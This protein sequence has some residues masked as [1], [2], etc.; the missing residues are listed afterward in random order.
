MSLL[1][2]YDPTPGAVLNPT[3]Y[4][5]PIP[6]FPETV[7]LTFQPAL[8]AHAGSMEGARV[9]DTSHVF[10]ELPVYAVP[11]KGRELAVCQ[12]LLGAAGSAAV[13]EETIARG[14][15]KFLLFGSCGGLDRSIPPGHVL[16]PTEAYRDEGVSYH[17]LPPGD[18]VPLPTADRLGALLDGLGLPYTKGRVWTT[19][20]LYRETAR[21]LEARRA[22]GCLA[23]DMECAALAAVCAFRGAELFQF[24]YTEDNLGGESWDPG[25]L[26]SLPADAKEAFFKIALET[27]IQL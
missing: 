18:Y 20:G 8:L 5:A 19:D 22:E 27:A 24:L 1:H 7:V 14:G 25:L 6:G 26:G 13:L 15:R 17:Y 9:L 2:T 3:D 16:L 12:V 4:V 11:Y 21:N 23:V 10:F